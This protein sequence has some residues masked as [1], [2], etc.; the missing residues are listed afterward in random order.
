MTSATLR[1]VFAACT[2]ACVVGG[3]ASLVAQTRRIDR[4]SASQSAFGFYWETH[5]DPPTPPLASTFGTA[6]ANVSPNL[7]YRMLLDRAKRVYFGYCA[8]IE[9]L[10]EPNTFRVTF[11]PLSLVPALQRS[12]GSDAASWTPL[13]APKFPNQRTV[14]GGEVMELNLLTNDSWGQRLIEYVTVQEPARAEG[15]QALTRAPREFAFATGTPHDFRSDD[16]ELQLEEPRVS[17]NGTFDMSSTRTL[18]DETGRV[19]WIYIPNRGRFQFSLVPLPRL[20]FKLAGETRGSSLRFTLGGD[21]FTITAARRIAPGTSAF[22]VYVLHQPAWRPTY[23]NANVD[24]MVMGS[25]D[26][27]EYLAG[28]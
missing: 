27:A 14:R 21:T 17:I 6:Y 13:P 16:V 8:R 19:V 5:L 1:R 2:V 10:D 9:P 20:G 28:Q 23:A 26:R 7:V 4:G 15:F 12:L 22:N 25:A 18:G 24:A 11:G 3:H